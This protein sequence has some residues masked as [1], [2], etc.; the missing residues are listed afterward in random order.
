M[1]I[2][3]YDE[4]TLAVVHREDDIDMMIDIDFASPNNFQQIISYRSWYSSTTD[5]H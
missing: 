4:R 1:M 3:K 2:I 5:Q